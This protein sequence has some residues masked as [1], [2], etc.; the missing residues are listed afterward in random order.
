M[1]NPIQFLQTN[2]QML[3][4]FIN[5]CSDSAW[6]TQAKSCKPISKCL[7]FLLIFV[8][9]VLGWSEKAGL[10]QRRFLNFFE[11]IGLGFYYDLLR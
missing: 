2:K 10:T 11:R 7:R 1:A 6:L 9:I 5:I 8:Q 3:K 4:V